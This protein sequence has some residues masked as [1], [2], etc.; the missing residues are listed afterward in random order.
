[1]DIEWTLARVIFGDHLLT[2][3]QC[4]CDSCDMT[5]STV[6]DRNWTGYA[7]DDPQNT[8]DHLMACDLPTGWFQRIALQCYT[9]D[10]GRP[11]WRD[12]AT[13]QREAQE[14]YHG[15][16]TVASGY[17]EEYIRSEAALVLG[18][19]GW[20]RSRICMVFS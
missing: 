19:Y 17:D 6:K 7:Q 14:Y 20:T 12:I 2:A 4:L 1:M 13:T 11:M 5:A 9:H 10:N 8:Y 3:S 15:E 18:A 16:L